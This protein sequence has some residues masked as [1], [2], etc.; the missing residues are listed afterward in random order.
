MG[1]YKAGSWC[2]LVCA[3]EKVFLYREVAK[4]RVS[5]DL[6]SVLLTVLAFLGHTCAV[7]LC[8]P[9]ACRIYFT[10]FFSHPHLLVCISLT[11]GTSV[12]RDFV[13]LPSQLYEHWLSEVLLAPFVF[14]ALF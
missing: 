3:S 1:M 8:T 10:H 12:L 13:E 14:V 2:L 9:S 11:V 5:S 7:T 4:A 6:V